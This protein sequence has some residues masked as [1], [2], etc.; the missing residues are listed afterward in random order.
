MTVDLADLAELDPDA[1]RRDVARLERSLRIARI[2]LHAVEDLEERDELA[3]A[4]VTTTP[5]PVEALDTIAERLEARHGVTV[6]PAR[7]DAAAPRAEA[8]AAPPSSSQAAKAPPA[9]STPTGSPWDD[10]DLP[11]AGR[12]RLYFEAHPGQ[13]LAPR[14]VAAALPDA[15]RTAVHAACKAMAYKG[16]VE[17]NGLPTTLRA[18][19]YPQ[20]EEEPSPSPETPAAPSTASPS[21]SPPSAPSASTP[22]R[23]PSPPNRSS[24]PSASPTSPPSSTAPSTT[25]A[26]PTTATSA[27][28]SPPSVSPSPASPP[29]QRTPPNGRPAASAPSP[30]TQTPSSARRLPAARMRDLRPLTAGEPTALEQQ[31]NTSR[32]GT[33]AGRV[34]TALAYRPGTLRD[35]AARLSI[36]EAGYEN[37]ARTIAQLRREDSIAHDG[38]RPTVY[39]VTDPLLAAGT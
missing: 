11:A 18:Y 39:S 4:L 17:S 5:I 12:V 26:S 36:P 33:L 1:V 24:S 25:P 38:G 10:D 27:P 9:P 21:P 14:A 13:W 22:S 28:S 2:I 20:P 31:A 6:R 32:D 8:P 29:A 30:S 7:Q 16:A 35:L 3:D 34:L 19:R 37:L 15:P 23:A